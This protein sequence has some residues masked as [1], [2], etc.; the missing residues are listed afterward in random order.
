MRAGPVSVLRV[1]LIDMMCL[2]VRVS[3]DLGSGRPPNP[4][5]SQLSSANCPPK[6]F[7]LEVIKVINPAPELGDMQD[8]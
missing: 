2:C 4:K 8:T 7:T 1:K 6:I 3:L 5:N